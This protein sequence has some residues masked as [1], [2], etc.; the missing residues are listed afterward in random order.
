M[1]KA[2]YINSSLL[3][4][5]IGGSTPISALAEKSLDH[6]VEIAT[7]LLEEPI[8]LVSLPREGRT[9]STSWLEGALANA[10]KL[11]AVFSSSALGSQELEIIEDAQHDPRLSDEAVVSDVGMHFCV[12]ATF[13]V[14]DGFRIGTLCVLDVHCWGAGSSALTHAHA[15]ARVLHRVAH[16]LELLVDRRS[17]MGEVEC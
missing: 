3:A 9:R 14:P 10:S 13:H 12:E 8:V 6:S 7:D 11:A 2:S 15:G 5:L 4:I 1:F 16:C 17:R